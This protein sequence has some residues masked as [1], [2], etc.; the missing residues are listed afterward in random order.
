MKTTQ[1]TNGLLAKFPL[2]CV[3]FLGWIACP[4]AAQTWGAWVAVPVGGCECQCCSVST[5]EPPNCDLVVTCQ[6]RDSSIVT[7]LGSYV[8][9]DSDPVVCEYC[10]TCCTDPPCSCIGIPSSIYC[11]DAEVSA[12]EEVLSLDIASCLHNGA[13]IQQALLS[14]TGYTELSHTHICPAVAGLCYETETVARLPKW[15]G[16]TAA[17]DHEW[18]IIRVYRGLTCPIGGTYFTS[19]G[20]AKSSV[21]TTVLDVFSASCLVSY[22]TCGPACP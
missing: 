13:T 20:T 16:T 7:T 18:R 11:G 21:K 14:E 6:R 12:D 1:R 8:Y 17:M 10:P 3:I 22:E 9:D 19:C 15:V 4:C 5:Y 2:L